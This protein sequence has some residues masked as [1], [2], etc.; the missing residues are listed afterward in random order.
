V[1]PDVALF[2]CPHRVDVC[3]AKKSTIAAVDG[4]VTLSVSTTNAMKQND[5]C[6]W[7]VKVTCGVPTVELTTLGGIFASAS[8]AGLSYIEYRDTPNI[9]SMPDVFDN[10][11]DYAVGELHELWK[12]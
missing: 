3:G 11:A 12:G 1:S 2:N 8:T 10:Q 9:S 6:H 4:K 5:S 7:E